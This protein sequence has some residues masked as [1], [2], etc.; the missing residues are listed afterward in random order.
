MGNERCQPVS[1]VS[2][3]LKQVVSQQQIQITEEVQLIV[4]VVTDLANNIN[5]TNNV[6]APKVTNL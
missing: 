2:A 5:A 6:E 3:Q 4:D 1:S